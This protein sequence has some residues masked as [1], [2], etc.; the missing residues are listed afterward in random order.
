[1]GRSFVVD[2][3]ELLQQQG[4]RRRKTLVGQLPDVT[5]SSA[6]LPE[7]ADVQFDAVLEAQGATVVVQ[8]TAY[9][10][11]EGECRRCLGPAE[12][13]LTVELQE[14]FEPRPVEGETFPLEGEQL[15]LA[16][17]L[18]EVLTL[19][20]PLAPLCRDDCPGPDP[21][22]HPVDATA[23]DEPPRDPRWAAFDELNFD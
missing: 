12:G 13:E 1:M 5:L 23:E 2:V 6:R 3:G 11:W 4:M 17:M 22:S 15:D 9:A 16:P 20:L 14:I 19:A 18:G 8:G 21:E 7:G 10:P